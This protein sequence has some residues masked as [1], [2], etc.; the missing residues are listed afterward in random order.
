MIDKLKKLTESEHE[1]ICRRC[2]VCCGSEDGD[3]CVHLKKDKQGKYC[4]DIYHNRLGLRKTVK[5]NFF[6]CIPIERAL[7]NKPELKDKCAYAKI[8]KNAQIAS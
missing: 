7:K 1:S 5:G 4:C 2:G 6:L 8:L 3:P